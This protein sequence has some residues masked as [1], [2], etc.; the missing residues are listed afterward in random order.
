MQLAGRDPAA[1]PPTGHVRGAGISLVRLLRAVVTL[2]QLP[3]HDVADHR[4]RHEAEQLQDSKDGAIK[5]HWKTS[6][7]APLGARNP[8]TRALLA[9]RQAQT[10]PVRARLGAASLCPR[11]ELRSPVNVAREDIAPYLAEGDPSQV[12]G[13]E[14]EPGSRQGWG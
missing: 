11:A 1:A 4:R 8:P 10:Q 9:G 2:L 6:G 5:P 13:G 7:Q 14:A 12:S 3:V